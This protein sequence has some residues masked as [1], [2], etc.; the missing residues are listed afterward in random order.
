MTVS[1]L[2]HEVLWCCL[3]STEGWL[4]TLTLSFV[5][6]GV[7]RVSAPQGAVA[8]SP[9]LWIGRSSE[10]VMLVILSICRT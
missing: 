1:F 8:L 3:P 5:V 7:W 2:S 9:L 4:Q 6:L 10:M